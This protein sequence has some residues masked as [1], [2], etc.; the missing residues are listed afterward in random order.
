MIRQN[1]DIQ[2]FKE[3]ELE[4]LDENIDYFKIPSLSTEVR[5]K[6]HYHKPATIGAAR[7]ISGVTPA[8][9]IAIII[10]IKTRYKH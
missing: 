1:A 3:E 4:L 2:L 9:L 7:R 10:Y 5:E 8:A 6:L